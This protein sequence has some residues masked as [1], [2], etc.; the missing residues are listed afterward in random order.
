MERYKS[1]FVSGMAVGMTITIL[2]LIVAL[3]DIM[4]TL[5]DIRNYVRQQFELQTEATMC[6]QDARAYGQTCQLERDEDGS[7]HYYFN[8]KGE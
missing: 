5:T 4:L 6:E 1:G 2:F 8:P 7:Y 3:T